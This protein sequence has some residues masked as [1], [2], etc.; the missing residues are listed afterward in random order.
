M[1]LFLTLLLALAVPGLAQ[2]QCNSSTPVGTPCLWRCPPGTYGDISGTQCIHCPQGFIQ[3]HWGKDRCNP[4][5]TGRISIARGTAS[6]A[7]P[8]GSFLV[9][10]E[11]QPHSWQPC[12]S[13]WVG[14]TPPS[15]ACRMCD[16]GRS[17]CKGAMSCR[18]CGKGKFA[19]TAGTQ[20]SNCQPGTFQPQDVKPS[21]KCE[22]CPKGKVTPSEGSGTCSYP[23][24][25][26]TTPSATSSRCTP[27][28]DDPQASGSTSFS[29]S[30]WVAASVVVVLW[31]WMV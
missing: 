19:D 22:P 26:S 5:N 23:S 25:K 11:Q 1:L 27:D 18:P 17:S 13:G 2:Y 3:E 9:M 20:C 28:S 31:V 29:V 10:Y 6:I 24:D 8:E 16:K 14:T 12:P 7:V 21:V 30:A 4:V 15:S